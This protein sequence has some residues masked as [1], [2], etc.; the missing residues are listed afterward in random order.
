MEHAGGWKQDDVKPEHLYLN[1]VGGAM[2][3]T[4]DP[5][6][7]PRII[8]RHYDVDGNELN[9]FVDTAE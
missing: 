8:V 4:I 2:T 5:N 3:V 9:K 1:V 6:G 7:S